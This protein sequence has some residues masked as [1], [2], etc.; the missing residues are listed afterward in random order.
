MRARLAVIIVVCL[1]ILASPVAATTYQVSGSTTLDSSTVFQQE[2]TPTG[3]TNNSSVQQVDPESVDEDGNLGQVESYLTGELAARLG[4]SALTISQGE[5]ER[6]QE[7]LGDEYRDALSK[8]VDVAGETNTTQA[9]DTAAEEQQNYA[10]TLQEYQETREEYEEAVAN[11]N[12]P[13]A[14][15]LARQLLD[16]SE[17]LEGQNRTVVR[18]Y[19]RIEN[20]TGEDTDQAEQAIEATTENISNIT[21]EIVDTEFTQTVLRIQRPATQAQVAFTDPL[22][23]DGT[24]RTET[25]EPVTNQSVSFSIGDR[26]FQTETD[27]DGQFSIVYRPVTLTA[28]PQTVQVVFVPSNTSTLLGNST[29]IP[30]DIQQRTGSLSLTASNSTSFGQSTSVQGKLTVN[31]TAVSGLPVVVRVGTTRLGVVRTNATGG[32]QLTTRLP[33]GIPDETQSLVV[34]PLRDNAAVTANSTATDIE[35]AETATQLTLG[36]LTVD[37]STVTVTGQLQTDNGQRIPNEEIQ[38]VLNG[39]T[40]GTATTDSSGQFQARVSIPD[41]I[42]GQARVQA[43]YRPQIGNLAPSNVSQL[44]DVPTPRGGSDGSQSFAERTNQAIASVL[45][46]FRTLQQSPFILVGVITVLLGIGSLA[47]WSRTGPD[48]PDVARSTTEQATTASGSSDPTPSP[49][50]E[51]LLEQAERAYDNGAFDQAISLAFASVRAKYEARRD[52]E[53]GLTHREL[54]RA[55]SEVTNQTDSRLG[56]LVD[57]YERTAF[58]NEV[59]SSTTVQASLEIARGMQEAVSGST[60][61]TNATQSDD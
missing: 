6:G 38:L 48:S 9:F 45:T 50:S 10:Q 56:E 22:R 5:Y 47:I 17:Q 58:A 13:R 8:Y 59:P 19:N 52:I 3:Q 27:S 7:L 32:Y 2:A 54:R 4:D 55:I 35:I 44:A 43:Q 42:S 41:T 15:E 46:T 33:A 25:G 31:G 20:E 14:R 40:V 11:G 49:L 51:Q 61:Q 23:L 39:T 1:S 28:G 30:V 18:A 34:E 12:E 60:S 21:A 37:P 26:T 24:L 57:I 53:R 29:T 16:L 36:E